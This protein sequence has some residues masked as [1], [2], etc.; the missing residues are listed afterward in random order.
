MLV[1]IIFFNITSFF[2]IL[3]TKAGTVRFELTTFFISTYFQDKRHKP[4]S[5]KY[6]NIDFL[7]NLITTNL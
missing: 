6:P 7:E 1:S 4:D 2:L 5:A 3:V